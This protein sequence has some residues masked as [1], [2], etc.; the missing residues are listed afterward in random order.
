MRSS[1][2]GVGRMDGDVLGVEGEE[3]RRVAERLMEGMVL[4]EMLGFG[5][6]GRVYKGVRWTDKSGLKNQL[7]VVCFVSFP[8]MSYITGVTVSGNISV[9]RFIVE[10]VSTLV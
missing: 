1:K 3:M 2:V 5:S 8:L 10:V 7:W 9:N 4:G 6:Y